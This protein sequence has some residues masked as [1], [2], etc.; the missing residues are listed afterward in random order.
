[1]PVWIT[2]VLARRATRDGSR[3]EYMVTDAQ[4]GVLWVE[5]EQ[6]ANPELLWQYNQT[7]LPREHRRGPGSDSSRGADSHPIFAA[8]GRCWE[9]ASDASHSVQSAGS[10]NSEWQSAVSQQGQTYWYNIYSLAR[11][12]PERNSIPA[13][14]F[15]QRGD[16]SACFRV[17]FICMVNK[18]YV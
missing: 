8:S 13:R 14:P 2:R 11:R 10:T 1:M 17:S 6:A 15:G 9:T 12:R 5:Q 7:A 18:S 16:A 3:F 4:G